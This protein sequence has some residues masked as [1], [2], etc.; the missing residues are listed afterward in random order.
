MSNTRFSVKSV[1]KT[2]GKLCYIAFL[3][4]ILVS[5]I[6]CMVFLNSRT[7]SVDNLSIIHVTENEI[8]DYKV[9]LEP[10]DKYEE[11]KLIDEDVRKEV[12]EYMQ[13]NNYK[14]S[15]GDQEFIN[16]Q[17]TLKE[18]IKGFKFEPIS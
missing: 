8:V 5:I 14:L 4:Y 15:V 1:V 7:Y 3:L 12:A 18:L 13:N 16:K 11:L 6:G 2:I 17:P 10:T 9:F